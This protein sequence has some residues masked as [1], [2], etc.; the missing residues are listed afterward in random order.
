MKFSITSVIPVAQYANVQPCI[1][2]EADTYEEALAIVQ[3]QVHKLWEQYSPGTLNVQSGNRKLLKAFCG[4]D[5]YYDELAHIYTNE[6]GDVYESG[7]QY[8][9]KFRKPFD[10]DK[11]SGLMASKV[12]DCK[13]EDIVKMWELKG[14]ASKDFGNAIHKALQLHEQYREL[15]ESLEKTTHSHDHPVIKKAVDGFINAHTGEKVISEALIVDH[16]AKRAGQVDR[17]LITSRKEGRIQDF[18]TNASIDKDLDVYWKQLQFYAGIMEAN[19]WTITGYDI[20]HYDGEW[21]T[22]SKERAQ[23]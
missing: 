21:H 7:S 8:A 19:G 22:Y 1:E 4:G 9:N 20:F 13:P 6:Q 10:K 15:A 3:P 18:K 17:L 12:K 23:K 11:I 5:V 16:E 14:E 2:V